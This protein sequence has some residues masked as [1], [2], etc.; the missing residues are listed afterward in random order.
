M[1]R[2]P[3]TSYSVLSGLVGIDGE[4]SDSEGDYCMVHFDGELRSNKLAV[5]RLYT[6][7]FSI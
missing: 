1:L 5:V 7:S 3:T 6:I 2:L 4:R